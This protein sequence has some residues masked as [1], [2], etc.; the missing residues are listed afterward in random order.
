M[1]F[2][3]LP[4]WGSRSGDKLA[5][6]QEEIEANPL[7]AKSLI[8]QPDT[9]ERSIPVFTYEGADIIECACEELGWPNVT[10]DG[11]MMYENSFTPDRAQ[12]LRWA[13]KSA[14]SGIEAWATNVAERTAALI[15]ARTHLAR[16]QGDL[17][18]LLSREAA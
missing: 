10:H 1:S 17:R 11:R 12:A 9:F 7:M 13:I 4:I 15:E 18:T 16:R 5:R 8:D 2:R 3:S 14:R 6:Y